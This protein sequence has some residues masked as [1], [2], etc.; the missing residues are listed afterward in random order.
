MH[1]NFC[2]Q[3]YLPTNPFPAR[4]GNHRPYPCT[5]DALRGVGWHL[6]EGLPGRVPPFTAEPPGGNRRQRQKRQTLTNKSAGAAGGGPAP[7]EKKAAASAPANKDARAGTTKAADDGT[8]AT[9]PPHERDTAGGLAA[10]LATAERER[11]TGTRRAACLNAAPPTREPTVET[12]DARPKRETRPTGTR[13]PIAGHEARM[14]ER[15]TL[16]GQGGHAPPGTSTALKRRLY[17][18]RPEKGATA[19]WETRLGRWKQR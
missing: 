16:A 8:P 5:R 2:V 6:L 17:L 18:G 3:A 12:M 10:A 9:L 4:A 13:T 7:P 14:H 15:K 19:E 1:T 11:T